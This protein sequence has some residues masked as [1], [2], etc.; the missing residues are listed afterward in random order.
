M[1]SEPTPRSSLP[2]RQLSIAGIAGAIVAVVIVAAGVTVRVTDARRLKNW[3]EAEAIPTVTVIAPAQPASGGMLD[4]PGR[5]EAFT[6][7]PIYARVSG[8]LKSW[9]VDIGDRVKAGEELAIIDTPELDQQLN[10]AKADLASAQADASLAKTSAERWQALLASD[11]VSRQEVD[12]R[13]Q[14]YAAK[15][16]RVISAQANVDRLVATK[17]FAKIVAPFDGV[18]TARNTDIGALINAGSGSEAQLFSVSS[19]DKLR[20]YVHVPQDYAPMVK[21]GDT[22]AFTVPEF[23]GKR[24]AAQVVG[25]ADSVNAA[26]GTTLVQLMVDNPGHLLLPGSFVNLHFALPVRAG[27]LRVPASTLIFDDHGLRLATVDD[28]DEVHFKPVAIEQDLGNA[29]QIGSGLAAS[30]RVIDTPPDGL[31]EGD[32][33]HVASAAG[34]A[35]HHG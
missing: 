26:S 27:T 35:A 34:K 25:L 31:A 33:V 14:D 28:H 10:Q 6:S 9:R 15:K 20:V 5:L 4:L 18:I 13:T 30:D 16:A 21:P 1:S 7:A 8:Y 2:Q 22:A 17:A 12:D 3:T 24:F 19:V 23:P 32:H 29:V 11:S